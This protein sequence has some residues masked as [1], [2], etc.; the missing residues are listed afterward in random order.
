[1]GV[2]GQITRTDHCENMDMPTMQT[3]MPAVRPMC[4]M[5]WAFLVQWGQVQLLCIARAPRP[6]CPP[7]A[8]T[9][10]APDSRSVL[11]QTQREKKSGQAGCELGRRDLVR[12]GEGRG[13]PNPPP[14]TS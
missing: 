9:K 1:M 14:P 11:C 13:Q 10:G 5:S 7:Q 8:P 6:A 12:I 4:A 2:G 3:G